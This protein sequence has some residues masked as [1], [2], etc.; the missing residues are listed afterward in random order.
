MQEGQASHDEMHYD[1]IQWL[2]HGKEF[3]FEISLGEDEAEWRFTQKQNVFKSYR[4]EKN[5]KT[6]CPK[7]GVF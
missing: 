6:K 2:Q 1:H 5:A 4:R 7:L 3:S